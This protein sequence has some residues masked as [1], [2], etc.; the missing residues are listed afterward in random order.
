MTYEERIQNET[1]RKKVLEIMKERDLHFEEYIVQMDSAERIK[2][3][4][5]RYNKTKSILKRCLHSHG[6]NYHNVL[7][8]EYDLFVGG[9]FKD[10]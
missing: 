9:K 8:Y 2:N 3:S 6:K 4:Q 10:L 1:D 7:I 5:V